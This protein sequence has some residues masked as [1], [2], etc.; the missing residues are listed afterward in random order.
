M[1]S[2]FLALVSNEVRTPLAAMDVNL[3]VLLGG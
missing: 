2:T 1:K 3:R